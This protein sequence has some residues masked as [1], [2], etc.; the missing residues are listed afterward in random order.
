MRTEE[1]NKDIWW[2]ERVRHRKGVTGLI[3]RHKER[4]GVEDI[5]ALNIAKE[6]PDIRTKM[7]SYPEPWSSVTGKR[8]LRVPAWN[9]WTGLGGKILTVQCYLAYLHVSQIPNSIK[10]FHGEDRYTYHLKKR[11]TNVYENVEVCILIYIQQDAT[12]HSL[13]YLETALHVF[14]WYL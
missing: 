2:N 1:M 14:G 3:C 4:E 12:L 9:Y 13:F 8:F 7:I 10:H 11:E 6:C 5:A